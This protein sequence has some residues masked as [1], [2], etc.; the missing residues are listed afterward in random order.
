[1]KGS[2]DKKWI[3][4]PGFYPPGFYPNR[5][6]PKRRL[7]P[8]ISTPDVLYAPHLVELEDTNMPIHI[9]VRKQ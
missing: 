9:L 7:L 8:R 6:L 3:L 4:P 1:M 2:A 5:L